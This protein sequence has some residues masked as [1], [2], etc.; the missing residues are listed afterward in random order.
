MQ[1]SGITEC[2]QVQVVWYA[3]F[4]FDYAFVEQPNDCRQVGA[5]LPWIIARATANYEN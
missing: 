2:Q 1:V 5:R 3:H 4:C